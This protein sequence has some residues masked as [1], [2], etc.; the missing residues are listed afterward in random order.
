[1]QIS[2]LNC[3]LDFDLDYIL[4]KILVYD[5]FLIWIKFYLKYCITIWFG[6]GLLFLL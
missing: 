3:G 5:L 6:R 4:S 2:Y 1:M